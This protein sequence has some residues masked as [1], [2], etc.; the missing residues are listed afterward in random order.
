MIQMDDMIK[1]D[2]MMWKDG[3]IKIDGCEEEENDDIS[4]WET[5]R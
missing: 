2:Q 4:Y 3:M 1:E 5:E